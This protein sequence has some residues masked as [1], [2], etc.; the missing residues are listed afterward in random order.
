MGMT[1]FF[2]SSGIKMLLKITP[3]LIIS[4]RK[5][6]NLINIFEIGL[7]RESRILLTPWAFS[8]LMINISY[9]LKSIDIRI[10]LIILLKASLSQ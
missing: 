9:Y 8:I 3:G 4:A 5:N 1:H 10:F 6:I 7:M 2:K